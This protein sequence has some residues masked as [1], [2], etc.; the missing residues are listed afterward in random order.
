MAG[1]LDGLVV[2]DASWGMPAAISTMMLADYGARVI[3]VERPG[4]GPDSTANVRKSTD[5]GKWSTEADPNTDAGRAAIRGL[6]ENA[7]V[8]VESFGVGKA[9]ALGLGYDELHAEFPELVYV[10]VTGYGNV[11]PTRRVLAT[12]HCST[13]ASDRWPSRPGTAKA[14]SSWAT[15]P[16]RTAPRSSPRSA[17]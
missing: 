17:S 10:S 4:G 3:K 9:D 13:P 8:F 7:D 6:I 15:R 16:C 12:R 1:P 14:P 2:I 5:R 11:G